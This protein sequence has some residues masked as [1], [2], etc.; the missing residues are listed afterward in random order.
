MGEQTIT[1]APFK[2]YKG[3]VASQIVATVSDRISE[4][5]DELAKFVA[6][7]GEKH[8]IRITR[9]VAVAQGY[10][11]LLEGELQDKPFIELP[12]T[13][14]IE[15]QIMAVFSKA[16]G[17]AEREV[18]EL[19]G[20][21]VISNAELRKARDDGTVFDALHAKGQDLVDEAEIGEFIA[22]LTAAN[23]LVQEQLAPHREALG[24]L[25]ALYAR[26]QKGQPTMETT[27]TS[28]E[29]SDSSSTDSQQPTDGPQTTSS[30]VPVGAS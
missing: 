30:S 18:L 3:V 14:S 25:R 9:E 17:F 6:E 10:T 23:D 20:L 2:T 16:I 8:K 27:T 22:L 1:L 13:P 21:V 24:K 12:D 29:Q 7:Y 15:E 26:A 11:G 19:V 5:M 4:L 28:T